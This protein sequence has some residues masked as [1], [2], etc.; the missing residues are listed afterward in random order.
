MQ[1]F[2]IVPLS[3]EYVQRIRAN[4]RDDFGHPLVEQVAT[5]KGPCRISLQLFNVGEYIR[6]LLSYSPFTIDNAYD[7]PGPV[8]IHKK[9]V[10]PYKD[11]HR[12][13]P[14][15]K[16]DKKSFPLSIIGYSRE[17]R[18]IFSRLVGD[19]DIDQLL[20]TVLE[21]RQD[22]EYLHVRHAAACCFICRVERA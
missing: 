14:A 12:F 19:D 18:I 16:A 8:F 9:E 2:R 7:Q 11:V 22:I 3:E 1:K 6:L 10:E 4:Q 20:S 15:I 17:Q 5:G 21:E 13:P